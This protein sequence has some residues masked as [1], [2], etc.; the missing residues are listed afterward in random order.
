MEKVMLIVNPSSGKEKAKTYM[1]KAEKVLK[2]RFGLVEV[3]LTEKGG[4]ATQFASDA[5]EEGF[6]AVIAMGGDGTLNETI[7]GLARHEKRPA[8]GFIPLGTV[9]DLARS[10]G[11]PLK[12]HKAIKMLETA[13]LKPMDVGK[14]DN[15]YF[16]NVL[17]IGMIAQAVDQVSVEQKTKFGP[18]AYFIEGLK[19]FNRHELLHFKIRSEEESF[20]DEAALVVAGLTNSVGGMEKWAPEAEL[21]DGLLHVF[22]LTKLG[23]IDAANILPQLVKGTLK[24]ANGVEYYK[25]NSLEI[26]ASGEG[27]SVNVDGDPGPS[28]PVKIEVLPSHLELF[29]PEKQ[30]KKKMFGKLL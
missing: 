11:I 21:D 8:F 14:I 2:N 6:Y 5:A 26:E 1:E 12:P 29:V 24:N 22:I 19:A 23:F 25:T 13:V 28:L 30:N 16:M 4:D 7:N 20:D 18:V 9:N 17:A 10:T 3:K 27:I 15:Q